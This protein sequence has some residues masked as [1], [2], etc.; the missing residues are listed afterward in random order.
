MQ[1][2]A[3]L[4]APSRVQYINNNNQA[5]SRV[6]YINNNNQAVTPWSVSPVLVHVS[7]PSRC[8]PSSLLSPVHSCVVCLSGASLWCLSSQPAFLFS[9]P[10]FPSRCLSRSPGFD[11]CLTVQ[12]V[13]KVQVWAGR[14]LGLA[15]ATVWWPVCRSWLGA[16]W[17][18]T[19]CSDTVCQMVTKWTVRGP[20]DWS[21]WWSSRHGDHNDNNIHLLI[22]YRIFHEKMCL[23]LLLIIGDHSL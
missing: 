4:Q 2:N 5:P 14:Q 15:V 23:L 12:I 10:A 13:S 19:R 21:P 11:R 6:Q 18:D 8:C 7:I 16:C 1:W 3:Y 22:F 9:A 17:S 20:G